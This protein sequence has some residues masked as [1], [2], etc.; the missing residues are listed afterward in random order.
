MEAADAWYRS[1]DCAELRALRLGARS[2]D[3]VFFDSAGAEEHL[4]GSGTTSAS[5]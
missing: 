3:A 2:G 4:A 5:A 1:D